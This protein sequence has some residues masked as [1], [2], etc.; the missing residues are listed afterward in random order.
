M[1]YFLMIFLV[2]ACTKDIKT[3]EGL[4]A[5]FTEDITTKKMD[6]DYYSKYTS[7]KMKESIDKLS[8]EE[9]ET[10]GNLGKVKNAKI[11]VLK[12]NCSQEVKCS[13]TYIVKYDYISEESS[14]RDFKSEV[15]KVANLVKDDEGWKIEDVSNIKTYHES[16][17]PINALESDT[18]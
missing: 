15:K 16:I 1:K 13:L 8:D 12:K 9:F 14:E 17:K 5:K 3:P 18:N 2:V 4:L 11:E 6:R 10:Y 7:G